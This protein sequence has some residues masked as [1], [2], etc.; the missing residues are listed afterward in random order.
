MRRLIPRRASRLL[1]GACL[2]CVGLLGLREALRPPTRWSGQDVELRIRFETFS[3]RPLMIEGVYLNAQP[4]ALDRSSASVSHH[5]AVRFRSMGQATVALG[6]RLR[7]DGDDTTHELERTLMPSLG[8]ACVVNVMTS[9]TGFEM[10]DC[11]A[12]GDSTSD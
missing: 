10:S 1:L 3:N 9:V 2:L 7:F 4:I 5:G 6:L 8:S 11:D 12:P